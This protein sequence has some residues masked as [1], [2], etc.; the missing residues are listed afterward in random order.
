MTN[1]EEVRDMGSMDRTNISVEDF[2]V[3]MD[4]VEHNLSGEEDSSRHKSKVKP[5]MPHRLTLEIFNRNLS[6]G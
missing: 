5:I 4:K 1:S 6:L 3:W 2:Q